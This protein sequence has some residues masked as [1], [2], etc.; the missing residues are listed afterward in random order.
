MSIPKKK[1]NSAQAVIVCV[2]AALALYASGIGCPI[3]FVTGISCPGCGMTRAWIAMLTAQPM[4]ALAYHPL[5]WTVPLVFVL[6]LLRPRLSPLL[7]NVVCISTI[8]AFT[9]V[10]IVRLAT[11][12][13]SN[14][15]FS[16][17]LTTDVVSIDTPAWL[18]L[19]QSLTP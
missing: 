10:W 1:V 15:L 6:P 12:N 8:I 3:K 11:P 18:R 13:E 9:V 7:F 17:M 5:Y 16:G 2:L 14:V 4:L 19:I